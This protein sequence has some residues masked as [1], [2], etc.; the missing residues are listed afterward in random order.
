MLKSCPHCWLTTRSSRTVNKHD[1]ACHTNQQCGCT[2]RARP[3]FISNTSGMTQV[4][5]LVSGLVTRT[6]AN[7]S[8][9]SLLSI[10]LHSREDRSEASIETQIHLKMY[11][12]AIESCAYSRVSMGNHGCTQLDRIVN[13]NPYVSK[14]RRHWLLRCC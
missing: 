13:N 9:P 2:A 5:W 11:L 4:S 6:L 12:A 10:V 7:I 14:A 3:S 1:Q 8:K